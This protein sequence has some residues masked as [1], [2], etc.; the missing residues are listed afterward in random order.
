MQEDYSKMIMQYRDCGR[1]ADIT[2]KT[3][4]ELARKCSGDLKERKAVLSDP[5]GLL[6]Y[7]A[8]RT[9]IIY[10]PVFLMEKMCLVLSTKNYMYMYKVNIERSGSDS[11]LREAGFE[12]CAWSSLFTLH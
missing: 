2:R 5:Y 12:S 8:D 9:C 7:F 4:S 11:R 3:T 1:L 10:V 6:L